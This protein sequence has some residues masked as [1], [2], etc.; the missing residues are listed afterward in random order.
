[1][2]CIPEWHNVNRQ[3]LLEKIVARQQPAV[4]RGFVSHWPAVTHGLQSTES[5]STYLKSFDNGTPVHAI[6][7][8]PEEKGRVHYNENMTGFNFAKNKLPISAIID[9]LT[10]YRNGKNPPCVAAQSAIIPD[11]LP[12][13]EQQNTLPFLDEAIKPRIWIG[14]TITVP[15]HIDDANNIACVISGK[16]R[17]TLFPPEQVTN[18]YI[19][20]IDYHPAG[21]PISMV[22]CHTPDLQRFPDYPKALAAAQVAE[23]EAGD[24]LYIPPVWWHQVESVGAL[25]ILVNYWWGGSLGAVDQAGGPIECLMHCLLNMQ[26]LPPETRAAWGTLFNH[27]V[28]QSKPG[29]F[30]YIPE[31]RRGTLGPLSADQAQQVRTSLIQ[32]LQRQ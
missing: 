7:T 18:L 5:I 8:A 13:F 17:F 20:P 12:G 11:C 14:N 30:D 25:N 27:F 22:R 23:L 19:G 31:F 10:R 15:A 32:K 28:F 26:H 9:L 6:M 24:A 16:R 4:L 1:M 3:T 29:Q 2:Q 21:A